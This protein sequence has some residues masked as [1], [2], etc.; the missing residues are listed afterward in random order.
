V[1]PHRHGSPDWPPPVPRAEQSLVYSQR[2]AINAGATVKTLLYRRQVALSAQD[3]HITDGSIVP[4]VKLY[5]VTSVSASPLSS[6][7]SPLSSLLFP[8]LSSPIRSPTLCRP[9]VVKELSRASCYHL[10]RFGAGR[11][12]RPS[13]TTLKHHPPRSPSSLSTCCSNSI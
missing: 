10:K 8:P 4:V 2:R 13:V 12:G 11:S 9:V 1:A 5:N 3:G 7:L 6:L